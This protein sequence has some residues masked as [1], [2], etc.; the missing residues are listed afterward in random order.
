VLV[1][2]TGGPL[3]WT[4]LTNV[5]AV[6]FNFAVFL[7]I[8]FDS[9]DV[10]FI[11]YLQPINVYVNIFGIVFA[12][13]TFLASLELSELTRFHSLELGPSSSCK[14]SRPCQPGSPALLTASVPRQRDTRVRIH[15]C[16]RH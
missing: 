4:L 14:L 9:V 15:G 2:F 7:A 3:I 5:N 16:G 6:V 1:P 11:L 10:S 13:G 12:T 8:V